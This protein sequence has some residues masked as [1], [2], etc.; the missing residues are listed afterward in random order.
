MSHWHFVA[1]AYATM[2]VLLLADLL[3][4]A[5]SMRHLR[6]LLMRKLRR[7]RQQNS[8]TVDP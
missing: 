1:L 8:S 7:E 3:P 4:P 2:V 6:G 5:L